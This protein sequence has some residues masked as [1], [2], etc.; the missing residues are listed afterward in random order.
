MGV[1]DSFTARNVLR[2]SGIAALLPGVPLLV[3]PA[4]ALAHLFG[5]AAT[6]KEE[7]LSRAAGLADAAAGVMALACPGRDMLHIRIAHAVGKTVLA[8]RR[9]HEA[10]EKPADAKVGVVTKVLFGVDVAMLVA[11]LVAK[12]NDDDESG[13]AWHKILP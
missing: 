10:D 4:F 12:K 2:A 6:P 11:L 1:L 3:A 7:A 13:S 9:A 8:G 5:G